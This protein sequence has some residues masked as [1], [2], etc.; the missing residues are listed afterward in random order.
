MLLPANDNTAQLVTDTLA[1]GRVNLAFQNF[2]ITDS[3]ARTVSSSGLW[4][5]EKELCLPGLRTL[6]LPHTLVCVF[7]AVHIS[8]AQACE[9]LYL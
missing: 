7:I 8:Y 4:L 6:T 1:G 9:D 5:Q 3:P 2:Q